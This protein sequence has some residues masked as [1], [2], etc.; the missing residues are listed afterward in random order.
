MK[1][2]IAQLNPTVGNI[3]GN[4]NKIKQAWE[5][6]GTE[7]SDLLVMPELFLM[8]YPS[9]DLLE[10]PRFIRKTQAFTTSVFTI[11]SPLKGS[12]RVLTAF[13]W[14]SQVGRLF[15]INP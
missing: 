12:S 14:F 10:R 8:G 7:S 6:S 3:S 2:T 9:R 15:F 11:S 4:L 1:V 13:L 5:E